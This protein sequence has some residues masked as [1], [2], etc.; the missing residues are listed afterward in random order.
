[1][2]FLVLERSS[3]SKSMTTT[4]MTPTIKAKDTTATT[5]DDDGHD[6]DQGAEGD[7]HDGGSDD[8]WTPPTRCKAFL[9][10][11][12]RPRRRTHPTP[13]DESNGH[14]R[15]GDSTAV[16]A[17]M[18]PHTLPTPRFAVF[19]VLPDAGSGGQL[20]RARALA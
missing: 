13:L 8:D 16:Q 12:W 15:G 19:E 4:T 3:A 17:H 6:E 7:K 14:A 11:V 5:N 10:H 20:V 2:I 18:P 9:R 1:M